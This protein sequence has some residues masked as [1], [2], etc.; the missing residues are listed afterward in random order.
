MISDVIIGGLRSA[1]LRPVTGRASALADGHGEVV[2]AAHTGAEALDVGPV[3]VQRDR[4]PGAVITDPVDVAWWREAAHIP[5]LA[6][7]PADLRQRGPAVAQREQLLVLGT[8]HHA[9]HA[10]GDMIMDRRLLARPPHQ[11]ADR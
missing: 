4:Y 9:G 6:D 3:D 7:I 11:R 1:R 10:P 8:L 5:A 2:G